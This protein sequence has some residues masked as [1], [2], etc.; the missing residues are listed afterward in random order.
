MRTTATVLLLASLLVAGCAQVQPLR[1]VSALQTTL[2]LPS[3]AEIAPSVSGAAVERDATALG[4][5]RTAIESGALRRSL[6]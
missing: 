2:P 1:E 4:P 5:N 3:G 6:G